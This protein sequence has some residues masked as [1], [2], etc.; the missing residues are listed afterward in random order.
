MEILGGLWIYVYDYINQYLKIY[1]F[2]LFEREKAQVGGAEEEGERISSRLHAEESPMW[3]S[4][5]QPRDHDQSQT[6]SRR[7]NQLLRPGTPT[8]TSTYNILVIRNSSI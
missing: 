1:L 7:L 5:S 2:F 3:D 8:L 4:I 6:R